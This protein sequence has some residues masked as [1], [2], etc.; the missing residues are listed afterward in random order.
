MNDPKS[1]AELQRIYREIAGSAPS[2]GN[3]KLEDEEQQRVL[4]AKMLQQLML[5]THPMVMMTMM[6][7]AL[8]YMADEYGVGRE[9]LCNVLRSAQQTMPLVATVKAGG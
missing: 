9:H 5:R 1:N 6:C 2:V 7:V 8:G 4:I 3:I